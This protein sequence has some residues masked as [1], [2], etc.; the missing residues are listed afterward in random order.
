MNKPSSSNKKAPP[1]RAAKKPTPVASSVK[2]K[3]S[4]QVVAP[5]VARAARP[6]APRK[7]K[8]T[9]DVL[10]TTVPVNPGGDT[11][12]SR[13]ITLLNAPGG[14]TIAQIREATGWQAHTVRGTISGV[15][16][17]KLGYQVTCLPSPESGARLYRITGSVA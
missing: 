3:S 8:V 15:L 17:K 16:R 7:S 4:V 2:A 10:A 14:A 6:L 12:Q 11:K 13:L 5:E 9:P 1:K